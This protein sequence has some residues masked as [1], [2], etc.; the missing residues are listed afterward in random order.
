MGSHTSSDYVIV[1]AGSAGSALARRLLD[2]GRT[3]HVLEAGPADTDEAIH[4]PQGWPTLLAGPRDW[5]VMTVPQE[6][7]NGRSL[8]WPRGKVLGG[9][10]SLNG[11]IYMRGHRTDYDGWAAQGCTG[12]GWDDVRPLFL[13]SEDH[14]AGADE[15][16]ATGG[17][18]P[19]SRIETPHPT[20]QAFVDAAVAAGHKRTEDFNGEDMR[21][22][23]F[24]EMTV[25]DGRRMSAWQSFVA[26]VLDHPGLTVTTS[27]LIDRVVVEN[28][29]AVGVEYLVDGERH[30]A[31]AEGEVVLS[32]GTIGSPAILLRSG[33]GPAAH[34]REVGVD[35]VADV[36][37]V[38]ENLHDHPLISVVYE[39]SKP[40]PAGGNNLL[41]AQFYAD[42]TGWTDAAPD[43]QPLFLHL[44]YPAEGY[45]VP[46]HGYT[47]AAGIVAPKS[48]GT[49]RLASA[50]P[51]APALVD[52]RILADPYD[53]EALCDA[54][55]MSREVGAQ[56]AFDEWREREVAPGPSATTRDDI[57]E[58][59]R[60][61]VG[62]YHHQVGTC[63]MGVDDLAV[64]DPDLRVRGIDG[65]RVADASIMPV[66]P[67]GNTNA[68][69][70]MVGEKAADL[71]TG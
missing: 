47:I 45:E 46:E 32:A 49:L 62:T 51:T 64:V 37:G 8:F 44:V 24:T 48:R 70:I 40:L 68:P 33:I 42:S 26:P 21:G 16:H 69:S 3:V 41:E 6:H 20:A 1:G 17:P 5:T 28:G 50:D 12:W 14:L 10:S 66:V 55:E 31:R 52:P 7:A 35:V 2:A 9:S 65:L 36:A 71:I 22:V 53:L 59:A 43:L 30:V 19:V 58:F 39:A 4:S 25:R 61:S 54:I 67:S 34:L 11:M 63:R 57:R 18:L 38:G 29:R 27:A 60:R 15:H 56:R 23:G 13:R